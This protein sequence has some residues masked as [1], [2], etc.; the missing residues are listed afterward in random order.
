MLLTESLEAK[1][2]GVRSVVFLMGCNGITLVDLYG[3]VGVIA[4]TFVTEHADDSR[5]RL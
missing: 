4:T 1:Y 5:A 3:G 2:S